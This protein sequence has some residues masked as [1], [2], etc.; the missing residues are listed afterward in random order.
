MNLSARTLLTVAVVACAMLAGAPAAHAQKKGN[1]LKCP[2]N[3]DSELKIPSNTATDLDVVGTCIV[4]KAGT[5]KFDEV[6]VK[7]DGKLLFADAAIEFE[8]ASI[9]IHDRGTVQTGT[10]EGS[11]TPIAN[12]QLVIR[13]VGERPTTG[14]DP[15]RS[16][17]DDACTTITKGIA[18]KAGG[19]LRLLGKRGVV[20]DSN[21]SANIGGAN[22]GSASWTYLA[23]PAG[24]D[25]YQTSTAKIGAEV[26]KGGELV[27]YTAADVSAEW[28]PGDWIVIGTTSFSPFES[29]FVKIGAIGKD[30]ARTK[31][32]LDA[33]TPLRHYHFGGADPGRP[34]S[35]NAAAGKTTNYGVDERAEVG[36]VTRNVKLTAKM[37]NWRTAT[38]PQEHSLAWGGEL[39]VCAGFAKV[40]LQG[41]EIE[42]FGKENLGSYPVHLHMLG[43]HDNGTLL[44]N[45]NS[46]HH[47]YNHCFTVH[48]TNNVTISNNV[49]ARVIGHL[50][51]EEVP[52]GYDKDSPD[53]TVLFNSG[54]KFHDNLGL[55]AMANL[56]GIAESVQH[57][58]V[59]LADK[60]KVSVPKGYW[61][62]DYLGRTGDGYYGLYVNNTDDKT[63]AVHGQ[64]FAL[65][66]N[67]TLDGAVEV[68]G[69]TPPKCPEAQPYYYEGPSGFWTINPTSELIG[70]SIG[71]C[72]S[73]GKAYWY[74]PP[75]LQ[76]WKDPAFNDIQLAYFA[77]KFVNNRAHACYDGVFGEG[78]AGVAGNEQLKSHADGDFRKPNV[79]AEFTGFTATRIRNRGVWMRPTWFVFRH[80]RVAT[81]REGVT[82][83][84]SGGLDGNAPGV[85]GLLK[86][87]TIVGVSTNNVDRWG[88]CAA[89]SF[90]VEGPGCVDKN[91]EAT[92]YVPKSYPSPAW[93]FAGV[94][95]YDGP[96]RLHDVR[97]VN[98]HVDPR[99]AL[100]TA[101]DI[102][103]Q[104]A[105]FK[106]LNP[107]DP[108]PYEGDAALGW[109]QNNQ[110]AYPTATDVLRLKFDSVDLRHQVFTDKVNFGNFDDGD[111]NTAIIDR[112]GSLTGYKVLPPEGK[113]KVDDHPISLNNLPFNAAFNAADE[114]LAEGGQDAKFE[115]R[116]TSLISPGNYGTLE[117]EAFMAPG[118]PPG[119]V[120]LPPT[121]NQK[122]QPIT[123]W[124]TFAKDTTD[125]G[126]HQTMKLHS[127]N[128]QG[129]WEPKVAHRHGYTV[130]V[131]NA[132]GVTGATPTPGMPPVISVGLNDIVMPSMSATN[133][134]FV[135]VGV[136]YTG[137][138]GPPNG[139]F[140]I[141]RGY[142]SWGSGPVRFSDPKLRKLFVPLDGT[143][144]FK[145][146]VCFNS[147]S[148]NPQN[149]NGPN[150]CPARGAVGRDAAESCPAG[151]TAGTAGDGQPLC[152]Y[153][154]SDAYTPV[155]SIDKLTNDKGEPVD[156]AKDNY[157]YDK[158]TGM[159][160]F[161]VKQDR[162]NV[163]YTSPLGSCDT[164]GS[165]PYYC[166]DATANPPE[167]YYACPAEGCL[168]YVVRLDD[169]AYEPVESACNGSQ[170]TD[171]YKYV[172]KGETKTVYEQPPIPVDK[173][174]RLAFLVP[175]DASPK[176]T[177][178]DSAIVEAKDTKSE[179]GGEVFWH[180]Q[181]AYADQVVT[182]YCPGASVSGSFNA[183]V[184]RR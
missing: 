19:T 166:P 79:V 31:I 170:P 154:V 96:A 42:H 144:N 93:N 1:A 3:G 13:L 163:V 157:Y 68:T 176:P 71:G 118:L 134:F 173:R 137:K 86:D 138:N 26:A 105:F 112:D 40:E 41:V 28:K 131:K 25:K 46:I 44:L 135:R 49:C 51:Y 30:G 98:F 70:N 162:P 11:P 12:N 136:C 88:P 52:K 8:A 69:D 67:G 103:L 124:M 54:L 32:T 180:R 84:T 83:V 114:C 37:P 48:M 161:Y 149:L 62:G 85:W 27:I 45:S 156:I 21:A 75:T 76:N 132:T 66:G 121:G 175:A 129:I 184:P 16:L 97:L 117:F 91:P 128:N 33:T 36:L 65:Q 164:G 152:G 110:S 15:Y 90:T 102:A 29:E 111:K 150:G 116:P 23:E 59:E 158:D 179:K 58:E 148:Q 100:L 160:F 146:E 74:V 115:G 125:Y 109:F 60:T 35:L 80:A 6:N 18:V 141:K 82:L 153:A 127:R 130:S 145:G 50:F 126:A 92:S 147:S 95:I 165:K 181:P 72:Q 4:K 57:V 2:L 113:P 20:A 155:A 77:P 22:P 89:N 169:P 120:P 47:T 94:Y 122:Q 56:F 7:S 24:P 34:S 99:K 55:G 87:T 104:D 78:E 81:S 172:P 139:K 177:F 159:L 174:N 143:F 171:I 167:S 53:G 168:T 182:P 119:Q 5:Y 140:T 101:E 142:R 108:K 183:L 64:C 14:I 178:P 106:G 39:K 43:S 151:S 38:K 10:N 63:L 123:Q 9:L 17:S 107:A 133:P 61:E 73:T